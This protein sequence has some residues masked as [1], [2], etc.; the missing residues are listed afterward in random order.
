MVKA[1]GGRRMSL[2]IAM[3]FNDDQERYATE[4]NGEERAGRAMVLDPSSF[5]GGSS[6]MSARLTA[7]G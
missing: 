1:M 7:Q 2:K 4:P 5:W 3:G 6:V